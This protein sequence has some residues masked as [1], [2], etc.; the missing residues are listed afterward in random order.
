[1][2]RIRDWILRSNTNRQSAM[3]LAVVAFAALLIGGVILFGA[4]ASSDV[5]L[6]N[7]SAG[8]LLVS[9]DGRAPLM[10]APGAHAVQSVTAGTHHLDVQDAS[11]STT[12][13]DFVMRTRGRIEWPIHGVYDVGG[14]GRYFIVSVCYQS[15]SHSSAC[16]SSTKEVTPIGRYFEIPRAVESDID[17]PIP[18]RIKTRDSHTQRSY[19][20]HGSDQSIA[21]PRVEREWHDLLP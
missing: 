19:L 2:Q 7:T 13:D 14:F 17:Q 3:L 10:L 8:T 20:C 21:C 11:G 15:Y 16:E 6:D 5:L 9:L 18:R 12:R 4:V 1:M